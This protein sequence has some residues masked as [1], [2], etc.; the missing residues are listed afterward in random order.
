V[1]GLPDQRWG[2][3]VTAAVALREGQHASAEDLRAHVGDRLAGYK[4]PR[5]ISFGPIERGATGKVRL[6][7]LRE[8]AGAERAALAAEG[9]VR[10]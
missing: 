7:A 10:R 6:T 1:F 9:P 5:Y 3:V 2:E 4:K 8:R